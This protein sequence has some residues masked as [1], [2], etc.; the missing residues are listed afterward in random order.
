[1]NKNKILIISISTLILA[2]LVVLFI[3]SQSLIVKITYI[4]LALFFIFLSFCIYSSIKKTNT[5]L[6]EKDKEIK[7][8]NKVRGDQKNKI[9]SITQYYFDK[10]SEDLKEINNKNLFI[11]AVLNNLYVNVYVL[12]KKGTII[13]INNE[14]IKTLDLNENE[15]IGQSYLFLSAIEKKYLWSIFH[16][17]VYD[18]YIHNKEETII[19]NNRKFD[20]LKSV[21]I[22]YG[23]EREFL[24]AVVSFVEINELKRLE[25]KLRQVNNQLSRNLKMA[26]RVQETIIPDEEV[27][28]KIKGLTFGYRYSSM[29]IMGGDLYDVIQINKNKYAFLI[30]DVSGHGAAAAMITAMLK[31]SVLMH[32]KKQIEP[33][34]VLSLVNADL[35][36][37]IGDTG[38]FVSAYYG[39]MDLE[40]GNF[41]YANG[42]HIPAIL[43]HIENESI[44]ELKTVGTLLGVF[45]SNI[46]EYKTGSTQLKQGDRIILFTDGIIEARNKSNELYNLSRL[47]DYILKH[48]NMPPKE[49]INALIENLENFCE[50]REQTDDRAIFCIEFIGSKNIPHIK[51]VKKKLS[52]KK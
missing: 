5:K 25:K 46:S 28:S 40:T 6:S 45:D 15:I 29:E 18:E 35:H 9:L 10:L 2:L 3:Y 7:L 39:I 36:E 22:I 4:T 50:G 44:E 43:Y 37:L 20:I 12:N 27:F 13:S 51:N 34:E 19:I 52:E 42:G 49:F 1:M 14:L 23:E 11:Q 32:T 8:L 31:V 24:G 16:N 26:R 41:K 33:N 21:S 30:A 47:K 38:Y 17:K 48:G